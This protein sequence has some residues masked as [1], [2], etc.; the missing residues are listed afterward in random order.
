MLF[1]LDNLQIYQMSVSLQRV[2]HSIRFKVNKGWSTAVLLFYAHAFHPLLFSEPS[3]RCSAF[4]GQ[5]KNL[6]DS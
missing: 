1:F 5:R 2:F 3:L 4:T 6:R